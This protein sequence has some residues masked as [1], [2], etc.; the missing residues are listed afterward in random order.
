MGCWVRADLGGW[1]ADEGSRLSFFYS[2]GR[3][4]L[5]LITLVI[6][7]LRVAGFDRERNQSTLITCLIIFYNKI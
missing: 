6:T 4:V 2:S 3:L 7:S 1:E 5:F